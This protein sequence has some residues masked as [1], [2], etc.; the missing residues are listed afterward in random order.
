MDMEA[1]HIVAWVA[2]RREGDN[3]WKLQAQS[4]KSHK[5]NAVDSHSQS[6]I[7]KLTTCSQ[8][9]LILSSSVFIFKVLRI[10][11]LSQHGP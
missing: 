1:I 4:V 8:N 2:V 9:V 3:I 5:Q 6:L 11:H 10:Q 7:V